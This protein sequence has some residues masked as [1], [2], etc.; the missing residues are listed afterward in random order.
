MPRSGKIAVSTTELA[1]N[2]RHLSE[3]PR[4]DGSDRE[5]SQGFINHKDAPERLTVSSAVAAIVLNGIGDDV[6][7]R[8]R[9]T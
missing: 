1:S 4:S 6:E 9:R 5:K 3:K 7:I 2:N 8:S